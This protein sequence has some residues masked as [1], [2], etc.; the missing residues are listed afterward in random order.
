M[1]KSPFTIGRENNDCGYGSRA[2][3]RCL[4]AG[5]KWAL[6]IS[7]LM[8]RIR[9]RSLASHKRYVIVAVVILPQESTHLPNDNK[10]PA[11]ARDLYLL[12]STI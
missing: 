3:S 2:T 12:R 7:P 11:I 8:A 4:C 5:S 1:C 10:S 9:A 6:W